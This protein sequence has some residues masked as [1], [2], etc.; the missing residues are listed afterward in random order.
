MRATQTAPARHHV[1][2]PVL[3]L[4]RLELCFACGSRLWLQQLN[5]D[6]LVRVIDHDGQRTAIDLRKLCPDLEG[7]YAQVAR[8]DQPGVIFFTVRQHFATRE[9]FVEAVRL[10]GTARPLAETVH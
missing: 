2:F 6:P 3:Q 5:N 1:R 4:P 8:G 7:E 9:A 10:L